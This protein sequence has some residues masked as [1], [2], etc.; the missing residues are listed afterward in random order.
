MIF[1]IVFLQT[2]K[3]F[4]AL[5]KVGNSLIR[6]L[7]LSKIF[8]FTPTDP[9]DRFNLVSHVITFGLVI[10]FSRLTLYFFPLLALLKFKLNDI[11]RFTPKG[12]LAFLHILNEGFI[13][14]I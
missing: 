1:L 2:F 8:T 12:E 3:C 10:I 6:L 4:A 11:S 9:E 13:L 14:S 7:D 5:V